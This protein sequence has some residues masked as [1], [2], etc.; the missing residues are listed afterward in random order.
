MENSN[1]IGFILTVVVYSLYI[2]LFIFRLIGRLRFGHRFAIIQFF[3]IFPLVFLLVKA[4]QQG[5]L[6]LYYIQLSLMILFLF[7]E[8]LLDYILKIEFRK[9][10]WMVISYVM[11]FFAATGGLLGVVAAAGNRTWI[12]IAV[13]LFFIMAA[14]SGIQ[15][16]VTGM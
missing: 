13:G 9:V 6:M 3:L 11:L 7:V 12:S 5:R 8:L 14:L 2:L 15:R 1:L 4:P 10:R 16:R